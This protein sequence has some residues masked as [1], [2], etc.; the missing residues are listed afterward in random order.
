[1]R[2][3]RFRGTCAIA[4]IDSDE[5][6]RAIGWALQATRIAIGA[7]RPRSHDELFNIRL[8]PMY[9]HEARIRSRVHGRPLAP[10]R[11]AGHLRQ[12]SQVVPGR[13]ASAWSPHPS[14]EIGFS[15]ASFA[16]NVGWA[17]ALSPSTIDTE[18]AMV[19]TLRF[20]HPT[21][22]ASAL[23]RSRRAWL[24]ERRQRQFFAERF[25]R[26]IS[27]EA[28]SVGGD[29]EQDAAGLA[30]I[31][32]AEIEAVDLA[33]VGNAQFVEPLRPGVI[34]GLVRR[35]ERDVMHAAGAL[36]R[37]GKILSSITCSSAA[38]PPSPISNTWICAPWAA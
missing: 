3:S 18:L 10:R 12:L 5:N 15:P 2:L 35:A 9:L 23:L 19:G 36:P 29:L 6:R 8:E 11:A 27:G 20:V 26:L 37:G 33:A 24:E 38:G 30:E 22:S 17:K 1:M 13:I 34:L 16:E 25:H 7:F 31:E 14:Y 28:R 21:K 32:A 4:G